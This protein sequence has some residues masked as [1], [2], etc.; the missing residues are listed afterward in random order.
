[1]TLS[2]SEIKEALH[3]LIHFSDHLE[4]DKDALHTAVD[5]ITAGPGN[6]TGDPEQPMSHGDTVGGTVGGEEVSHG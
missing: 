2:I 5:A 6:A 3:N 4:A 1:M